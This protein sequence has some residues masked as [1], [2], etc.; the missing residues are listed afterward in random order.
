MPC[1]RASC[2]GGRFCLS[3]IV[4]GWDFAVELF[5]N[6]HDFFDPLKARGIIKRVVLNDCFDLF[7]CAVT[8]GAEK[9]TGQRE[10]GE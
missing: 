6:L 5:E 7:K 3:K 9:I 8:N 4:S 1:S 2:R 10:V